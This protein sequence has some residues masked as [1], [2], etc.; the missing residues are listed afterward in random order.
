MITVNLYYNG[1]KWYDEKFTAAFE[2]LLNKVIE[3]Q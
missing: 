3:F 2:Q 1:V